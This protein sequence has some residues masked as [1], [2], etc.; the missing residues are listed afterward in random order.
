MC[1]R[2][3][4]VAEADDLALLCKA[5]SA[6]KRPLRLAGNRLVRSSTTAPYRTASPVEQPHPNAML[7]TRICEARLCVLQSPVCGDKS[8]ILTR[9]RIPKH[10]LLEVAHYI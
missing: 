1:N 8:T 2:G 3:K 4:P 9:I 6:R 5:D 7:A 10:D